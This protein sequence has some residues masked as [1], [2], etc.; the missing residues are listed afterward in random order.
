MR[1]RRGDSGGISRS[2]GSGGGVEGA[3]VHS[4]REAAVVVG[5]RK[6]AARRNIVLERQTFAH[7]PRNPTVL[8]YVLST[9]LSKLYGTRFI[10]VFLELY[11]TAGWQNF[12]QVLPGS[13]AQRSRVSVPPVERKRAALENFGS[14]EAILL[15]K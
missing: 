10:T 1:S 3:A 11:V 7:T 14:W 8:Y 9:E 2:V 4:A 15:K 12:Q 5:R 6:R 13:G